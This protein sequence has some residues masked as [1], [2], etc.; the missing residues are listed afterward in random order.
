ML[1]NCSLE[2]D[3][4]ARPCL[5]DYERVRD[6]E[7]ALEIERRVSLLLLSKQSQHQGDL[8]RV[9]DW[10]YV[11]ALDVAYD[12]HCPRS[13]AS[14]VLWDVKG[15]KVIE[16]RLEVAS[17]IPFAYR[18]GLLAFREVP[19]LFRAVRPLISQ[20]DFIC[21]DNTLLLCDGNGTLHP[22]RCGVAC[23]VGLLL[24]LPSIGVAKNYHVGRP[25]PLTSHDS[26][27]QQSDHLTDV[28]S[29]LDILPPFRGHRTELYVE[30][31]LSGFLLRTQDHVRPIYVSPGYNMNI[32]VVCDLILTLSPSFRQPDPI[33]RADH[34]GR[35]EL[36]RHGS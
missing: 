18:P 13:V 1:N 20:H 2:D 33:R 3:R 34:I 31:T 25:P 5:Q 26:A 14:A 12:R 15:A 36:Q 22:R 32:R 9:E 29:L 16:E 8:D 7:S 21:A 6:V 11:I 30:N 24:Q 28:R 35:A 27:S 10:T 19:T 4:A 17:D 23:H